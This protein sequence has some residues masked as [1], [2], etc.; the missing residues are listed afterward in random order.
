MFECQNEKN[1]MGIVRNYFQ[2]L[3]EKLVSL[4]QMYLSKYINQNKNILNF[5]IETRPSMFP[6]YHIII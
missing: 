5:I 2:E 6:Y 1:A 4:I 3:D